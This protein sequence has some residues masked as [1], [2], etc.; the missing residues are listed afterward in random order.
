MKLSQV[1]SVVASPAG[2]V[3]GITAIG[4]STALWVAAQA[5]RAEREHP[6]PG[7]FV[8]VDGVRLHYVERGIGQPVILVHGNSVTHADFE[9]SGLLERLAQS[10]RVFAFDRPGFGHSSR[11]RARIWTPAAQ[12]EVLRSAFTQLGIERPVVVG[13][14]LGALIALTLALDDPTGVHSLVLLGGYYYPTGRLDVLLTLPIALPV[15]GDA[16]RYTVTAVA[17]RLLFK[18]ALKGM[19]A[20]NNVPAHF[21]PTLSREMMLRP[22]QMRASAED[23][24]FMIPAATANSE[25]Y[26]ELRMPITII[27]G[28]DDVVVDPEAHSVR[29]H[30][31][32]PHSELFLVPG[33]GHM[34]HYVVAD[35]VAATVADAYAAPSSTAGPKV[36]AR[37]IEATSA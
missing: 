13:H 6:A 11:P 2:L 18:R 10:H 12:A 33:V 36:D 26:S 17:G 37:V 34:V 28:A 4:A 21:V 8:E 15:I 5:R 7:R 30:G 22:V 1:K 20:P 35:K 29:L 14:S 23:A 27:A 24:A 16:M 32:I 9:A 25:R 31:D 3:T 19:F